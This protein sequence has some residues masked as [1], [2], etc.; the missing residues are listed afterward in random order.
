PK[1]PHQHPPV[2]TLHR[3][4]SPPHIPLHI[5]HIDPDFYTFTRHKILP[6][7]PIPLLYPKT[8]LLQNIE[9]VQFPPDI[10]DFLT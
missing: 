2:I 3:P 4:Q 7:T 1:I 5:Q 9:P 8:Q 6:P 10:I